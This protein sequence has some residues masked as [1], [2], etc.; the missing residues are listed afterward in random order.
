MTCKAVGRKFTPVRPNACS[1]GVVWVT[2]RHVTVTGTV[3]TIN[4]YGVDNKY[5]SY[6]ISYTCKTEVDCI[7]PLAKVIFPKTGPA[8]IVDTVAIYCRYVAQSRTYTLLTGNRHVTGR[9]PNH[10]LRTRTGLNYFL[11]PC[12]R[13]LRHFTGPNV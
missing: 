5:I 4:R 10:A 7:V 2:P 13:P 8:M 1:K 12:V 11:R 9:Y 6:L 3:S